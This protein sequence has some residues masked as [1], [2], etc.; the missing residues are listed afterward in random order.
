MRFIESIAMRI[1]SWY[2]TRKNI[3]WV[4]DCGHLRSPDVKIPSPCPDPIH[5]DIG[6]F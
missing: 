1:T 2:L 6:H 5:E 3:A 4:S